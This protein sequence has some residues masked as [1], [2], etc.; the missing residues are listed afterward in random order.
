MTDTMANN[1]SGALA[2]ALEELSDAELE[3]AIKMRERDEKLEA[4]YTVIGEIII[5]YA[6]DFGVLYEKKVTSRRSYWYRSIS[7]KE[8]FAPDS[9]LV[10]LIR[11]TF[12]S[13][14]DG[15]A[16]CLAALRLLVKE[17]KVIHP[18]HK[19]ILLEELT[20]QEFEAIRTARQLGK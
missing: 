6:K 12:G 5:A 1:A 19:V 16:C 18:K 7:I 14:T 13:R 8:L 11:Q 9:E 10:E 17:G 15:K 2:D 20:R 3:L 4:L